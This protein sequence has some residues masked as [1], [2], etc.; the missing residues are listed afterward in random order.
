M[1]DAQSPDY[2]GWVQ[3]PKMTR[4]SAK[5]LAEANI[6]ISDIQE[7]CVNQ[8]QKSRKR[9]VDVKFS[10]ASHAKKRLEIKRVKTERLPV[11]S[12]M[13]NQMQF[14]IDIIDWDYFPGNGFCL[15]DQV[16]HVYATDMVTMHIDSDARFIQISG[17]IGKTARDDIRALG[18]C[19]ST[20]V[21]S[22]SIKTYA[23]QVL[24]VENVSAFVHNLAFVYQEIKRGHEIS[25]ACNYYL[26]NGL[27]FRMNGN[28]TCNM[29][30]D[31]NDVL[32]GSFLRATEKSPL[33]LHNILC[34]RV[35]DF[36]CIYARLSAITST[37]S[38]FYVNEEA[39]FPCAVKHSI[40][41]TATCEKCEPCICLINCYG[42]KLKL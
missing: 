27:Y 21:S 28:A 15:L 35:L 30:P 5:R 29:I 6:S 24:N 11:E 26:G 16:H 7:P 40:L 10:T 42:K 31:Y 23:M 33:N 38:N 37:V 8:A 2:S 3:V 41:Q 14:E 39:Q 20:M 4:A 13:Y 22:G 9:K 32:L 36:A 19:E 25:T 1:D 34:L 18:G 12:D 17:K